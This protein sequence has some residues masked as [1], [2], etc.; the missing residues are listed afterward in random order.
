MKRVKLNHIKNTV[1]RRK[2]AYELIKRVNIK[3]ETGWNPFT[4]KEGKRNYMKLADA[5]AHYR[6]V[7]EKQ[8][9]TGD[10]RDETYFSYTSFLKN[11]ETWLKEK[12]LSGIMVYQF[13][14]QLITRYLE[15]LY[16]DLNRSAKTRDNYLSFFRVFSSFLVS[17]D[18]IKVKPT[19]EI[20][21]LGKKARGDKNRTVISKEDMVKIDEFIEHDNIWFYLAKGILYYCFIRPKEMSYVLIEHIDLDKQTIYVPGLTSKNG[22]DAVVTIP[23]KLIPLFERLNVKSYPGKMYLFSDKMKPGLIYRTEKQFR[24]YWAKV[25]KH[26]KFPDT[27]KF[28]SMKDTGITDMITKTGDTLAVRDQARHHSISITDMYTPHETRKANPVIK[29]LE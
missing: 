11:F 10:M 3:L 20:S 18:Y 7:I 29:D 1:E 16:V 19:E 28:Y 14:K 24:D 26:F 2:Y 23:S 5:F 12:R 4:E 8:F 25:R 17:N 9:K 15:Y 27:Y 22:K 21:V 6:K 13:D